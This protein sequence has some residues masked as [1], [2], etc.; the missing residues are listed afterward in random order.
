MVYKFC[1]YF[2][3]QHEF[4]DDKNSY[5]YVDFK[6]FQYNDVNLKFFDDKTKTA[7]INNITDICIMIR[8]WVSI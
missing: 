4:I 1:S 8:L 2:D 6:N 3:L 7:I 5:V